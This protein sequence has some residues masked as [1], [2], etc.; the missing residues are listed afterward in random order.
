MGKL[1]HVIR[2]VAY[3]WFE[4]SLKWGKRYVSINGF[5]SND[6]W[7]SYGVPQGSALG[8]LLFLLYINN[9]H[10]A[11]QILQGSSLCWWH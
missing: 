11:G 9:L 3:S 10:A 8:P 5:N 7:V 6:L 1:K 4:S 2:G